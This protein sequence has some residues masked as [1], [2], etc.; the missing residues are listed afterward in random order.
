VHFGVT[1]PNF[2]YGAPATRDHLL[3]VAQKAEACGYTSAWTSDHILVGSAFARY[4]T[5]YEALTTLAWV[6]GQT[7]RIRL[8]TSILI[9]PMRNAILAAKQAATIDDLT[10]GRF[11]LGV[12]LGWNEQEYGNVGAD[13]KHRAKLM[14]ES[15]EVVRNLWTAERPTFT[16]DF[17]RYDDTLFAPK[18][19]QKPAPPIWV[20]G[21]SD[22]AIHRAARFGDNWHGDEVMPDAFASALQ[23]LQANLVRYGRS[24][25][26]SVRFTV[27]LFP[28]T[29]Q[30]RKDAALAGYYMGDQSAVGTRGSFANMVAFVRRYRDMGATDFICQ[31]EHDTVAQHLDFIGVFATEVIAHI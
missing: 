23:K 13:W 25:A 17:Y 27:D 20:G 18:P 11:I 26:A 14:D 31:F 16:G 29:G 28:A 21:G 19:A 1:L 30:T 12:G 4:G 9:L 6:G 7:D 15:L 10:G 8:G 22:A 2:Q 24:V 5:L 3:A